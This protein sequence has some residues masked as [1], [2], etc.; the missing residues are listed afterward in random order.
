MKWH[1]NFMRMIAPRTMAVV[2]ENPATL[3]GVL[4]VPVLL[5]MCGV[6]YLAA[7]EVD[8]LNAIPYVAELEYASFSPMGNSG[9][10]VVPAS[11]ESGYDSHTLLNYDSHTGAACITTPVPPEP[12]SGLSG[13]CTNGTGN[14]SW[15]QPSSWGSSAT[16]L[17]YV[18]D[19][20]NTQ[21]GASW[22]PQKWGASNTTHSFG[23]GTLVGRD[24][25]WTVQ[26]CSL[27]GC[28]APVSGSNFSCV[29]VPTGVQNLQVQCLDNRARFDWSPPASWGYPE[30]GLRFNFVQRDLVNGIDYSTQLGGAAGNRGSFFNSVENDRVV[31]GRTY[32]WWIQACNQI[33]NCGG[34]TQGSDFVCPIA[35]IIPP[36]VPPLPPVV[37]ASCSGTTATVSWPVVANA[38]VYHPRVGGITQGQCLANPGWSWYVPDNSCYINN[39]ATTSFTFTGFTAGKAYNTWVHSGVPSSA[40]TNR[41]FTCL[42]ATPPPTVDLQVDPTGTGTFINSNV[43]ITAG[44][45]IGLRWTTA[46]T[47]TSCTAD[48][49]PFDAEFDGAVVETGGTDN[50][51][52]E[53]PA[54]ASGTYTVSCDNAGGSA[55]DSITV[56]TDAAAAVPPTLS[57][58]ADN[59][60]V[61][62]GESADLEWSIAANY[63]LTCRVT[64]G[65]LDQS[66]TYTQPSDS[67][68]VATPPIYSAQIFTLTCENPRV[69]GAPVSDTARVDVV[70]EPIDI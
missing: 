58:A 27:V 42:A 63:D 4:G 41:S 50:R 22:R 35:P 60:I 40:P 19:V 57:L 39:F 6:T 56:T 32:S 33:D 26:A 48:A 14:L 59:T 16:D 37:T 5:L 7:A 17:H 43:T 29:T 64:G 31:P 55:S 8:R 52:T 30:S 47:P 54:G 24:Y 10:S 36:S 15:Q 23:E 11:C 34:W 28:S 44:T 70:P 61:R 62:K 2:K 12:P 49:N 66:I 1:V 21:T 38:T 65:G 9:G 51:V 18:V 68:T 20:L 53:P 67:G 46:G 3:F 69:L 25:R 13:N 45:N